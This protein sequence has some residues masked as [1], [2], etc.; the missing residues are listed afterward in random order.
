MIPSKLKKGDEI[1]IIAPARSLSLLSEEVKGLATNRLEQMGFKVTFSKNVMSCDEFNSSSI[2]ERLDDIH[3]G[4]RDKNVKALITVIGGFN[5]NQLLEYLDYDLI[6]ANPKILCGYSDITALGNSIYAKTG[7]VT[8]SGP[9]Y[10]SFGMKK[11]F[12]YTQSYFSKCL[13][14][15]ESFN[16][17]PT[18]FWSD[19][20]WFLDQNDRIF[21]PQD[22]YLILNEGQCEGTIIGGNICTLNLLHG[23]EYMP[24]L[25]G[26]ILFLEDDDLSNPETFDRDLQSLIHQKG[27]DKVVGIVIGRFQTRFDMT[28]E[29][30]KKIISTK[31]ALETIPVIYN[32]NFGHTTPIITFPIGGTAKIKAFDGKASIVIDKH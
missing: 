29:K 21:Y 22:E 25:E 31:K 17:E 30:I 1:R 20:A 32:V 15:E 28:I 26:K 18:D 12:D 14:E 27:F 3:E 8:Y 19:D 13:I 9:H 6:A 16:L 7:L 23:T 10:S 2:E 24:D 5:T 4:F 11:S